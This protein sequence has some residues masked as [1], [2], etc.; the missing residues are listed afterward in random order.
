MQQTLRVQKNQTQKNR[1]CIYIRCFY[2]V[3][4]DLMN[5]TKIALIW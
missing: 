2:P 5:P 4:A 3:T 1:V